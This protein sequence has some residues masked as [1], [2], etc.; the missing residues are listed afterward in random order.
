M[1]QST[2][3]YNGPAGAT[4]PA[5]NG[6]GLRRR[7][8]SQAQRA[9]LGVDVLVGTVLFK[10]S[11]EQVALIFDV[12]RYELSRRVKLRREFVARH[13]ED[14]RFRLSTVGNGRSNGPG[15]ICSICNGPIVGFGNN[16]YPVNDGRCCDRCNVDCVI[17]ARI[18]RSHGETLA[19]HI[20]RSS[21]T[22][23]L[24]AAK[25]IGPAELWDSMI[26]PVVE[27]DRVSN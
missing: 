7:R 24:A 4:S 1:L 15:Q 12:P 20:A 16:A 26:S 8:L 19:E 18:E 21:P 3:K 22:E 14:L 13:P 10:P 2:P 23:R 25:I 9:N 5:I 11:L 27:E 17:P 6:R